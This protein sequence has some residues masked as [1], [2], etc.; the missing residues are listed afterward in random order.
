M[1]RYQNLQYPSLYFL[2]AGWLELLYSERWVICCVYNLYPSLIL[3]GLQHRPLF[4]SYVYRILARLP[5]PVYF[6]LLPDKFQ[7]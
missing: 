3:L 7:M 1:N 5:I 6:Y 4:L 2:L